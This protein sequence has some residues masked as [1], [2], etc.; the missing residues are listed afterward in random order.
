MNGKLLELGMFPILFV[1]K[2][3]DFIIMREHLCFLPGC[4][5]SLNKQ[6]RFEEV[7]G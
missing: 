3:V 1:V 6:D 7:E 2:L 4:L 5:E